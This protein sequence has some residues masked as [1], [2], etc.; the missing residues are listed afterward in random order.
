MKLAVIGLGAMGWNHVRVARELGALSAVADL[1]AE[2]R[3][4]AEKMYGV[5]A[6]ADPAAAFRQAD[7]VVIA[8]PTATHVELALAAI[9]AGKHVLV[10]KPLADTRHHAVAIVDAAHD[11]GVT[12]AVGHI[13]RHNPVV[14]YAKKALQSGDIGRLLTM[15][16]RRVSSYPGRIRDVGCILDIGIHEIDI[17][18]YLA[19][20]EAT[21]VHALAGS[22]RTDG[23]EDHAV[24][25]LGFANGVA[26]SIETNWLTP[27]RVRKCALTCTDALVELDYMAQAARISR[28][29]FIDTSNPAKYSPDLEYDAREIALR[30][31]EPLRNEIEDFL[32]AA[33]HRR[34]PLVGGKDGLQA[35]R[36]AEAAMESVRSGRS[37]HLDPHP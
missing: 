28:S 34:T 15:T 18:R 27:M 8:T 16:G 4:K 13:E 30:R 17:A 32:G 5:P 9:A 11:A 25:Q 3:S 35:L 2:A 31:Q 23:R 36:I 24:I 12:L 21:A 29:Q 6:S 14:A 37:I 20:S 10:E 22:S 26:A 19:G 1:S 7:A 33:Q